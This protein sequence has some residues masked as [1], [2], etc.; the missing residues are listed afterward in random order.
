MNRIREIREAGRLSV[1]DLAERVD[2]SGTQIR[3]LE[4]GE[5]RLTVEWMTRLAIAM[6]CSPADFLVNGHAPDIESDVEPIEIS[7]DGLAKAIRA[8]GLNVYKVKSLA[9]SEIGLRLG[10]TVTV[11]ES[12]S[13]L[14]AV[15]N[16][17]AVIVD[18]IGSPIILLRQYLR[19]ALLC[20]NRL[21]QN[22]AIRVGDRS[23]GVALRGV[24]VRD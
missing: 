24:V 22:S 6:E 12:A 20:T 18:V 2:T 13:A 10:N 14:A 1:D 16:A 15:E 17:S 11:D 19:P 3:R 21:G 23:M 5:R 9:L 7:I 8:R 4:S